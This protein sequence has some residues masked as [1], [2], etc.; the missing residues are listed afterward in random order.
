MTSEVGIG[1]S[2]VNV[3]MLQSAKTMKHPQERSSS[4][5]SPSVLPAQVGSTTLSDMLKFGRNFYVSRTQYRETTIVPSPFSYTETIANMTLCF[6]MRPSTYRQSVSPLFQS[7]LAS[8]TVRVVISA[9]SNTI[10]IC[11]I[12]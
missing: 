8:A 11:K 2:L 3:A 5:V 1:A 4:N 9:S 10:R 6:A 7:R 12:S